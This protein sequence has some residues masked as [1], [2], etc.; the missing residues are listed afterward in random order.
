MIAWSY[1]PPGS[2]RK[3]HLGADAKTS[4]EGKRIDIDLDVTDANTSALQ[5]TSP[6]G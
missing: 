6:S 4:G 5:I 2:A 1:T 3:H